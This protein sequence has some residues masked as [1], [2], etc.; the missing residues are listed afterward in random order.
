MP[1]PRNRKEHPACQT[2]NLNEFSRFPVI[3]GLQRCE[4]NYRFKG[5][6]THGGVAL[7]ISASSGSI[8]ASF[9]RIFQAISR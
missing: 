1:V 9:S 4:R 7:I 3:G 6:S 8:C 5:S 2:E